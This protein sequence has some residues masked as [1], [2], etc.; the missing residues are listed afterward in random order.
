MNPVALKYTVE[1]LALR[2][3]RHMGVS[4]GSLLVIELLRMNQQEQVK[5][6]PEPFFPVT[7]S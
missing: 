2:F 4:Y 7:V 6:L 3:F 1:D 5:K